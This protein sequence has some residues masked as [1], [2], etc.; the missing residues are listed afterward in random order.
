MEG[1]F[2]CLEFGQSKVSLPSVVTGGGPDSKLS[3]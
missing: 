3:C 2:D 1:P